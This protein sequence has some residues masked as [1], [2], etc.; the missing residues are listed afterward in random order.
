MPNLLE[1]LVPALFIGSRRR[2]HRHQCRQIAWKR[3]RDAEHEN[4]T[5]IA[6]GKRG[7]NLDRAA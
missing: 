5:A 7:C 1:Y 2:P 4:R 3:V 6:S